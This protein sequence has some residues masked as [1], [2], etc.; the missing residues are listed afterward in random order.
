MLPMPDSRRLKRGLCN[1]IDNA[2]RY[3]EK[4]GITVEADVAK[5]NAVIAVADN[6]I[7]IDEEERNGLFSQ[8]FERGG[9]AR[10][11][12][13]LGRKE[14]MHVPDFANRCQSGKEGARRIGVPGQ[15]L[16]MHYHYPDQAKQ[17]IIIW[18]I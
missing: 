14:H 16:E 3:T 18:I 8:T 2:I 10:Q 13:L 6:G 17:G 11:K 4:G 1:I 9:R 7:G 15:R 12:R 5:D